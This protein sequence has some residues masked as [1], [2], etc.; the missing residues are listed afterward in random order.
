MLCTEKGSQKLE[1][2]VEMGGGLAHVE[3]GT[4]QKKERKGDRGTWSITS[5]KKCAES[6]EQMFVLCG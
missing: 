3:I 1:T 4:V 6:R 5:Q 2:A